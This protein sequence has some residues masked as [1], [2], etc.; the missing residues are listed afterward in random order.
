M[1]FPLVKCLAALSETLQGSQNRRE[2][3][4]FLQIQLEKLL[5]IRYR[6]RPCTTEN[7]YHKNKKNQK[8]TWKDIFLVSIS[9]L[10]FW[11][12]YWNFENK[13]EISS[14][15][16]ILDIS[17][18]FTKSNFP[19]YSQHFEMNLAPMALIFFSRQWL[20]PKI[21]QQKTKQHRKQLQ[22]S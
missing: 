6:R 4:E 3:F 13:V 22:T 16:V 18:S 7:Y 17:T 10:K 20:H 19:L 9:R 14:S 1:F 5:S 12:S 8:K 2:S 21:I 11:N 15:S